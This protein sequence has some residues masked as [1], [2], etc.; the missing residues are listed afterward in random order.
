MSIAD[1][2]ELTHVDLDVQGDAHYPTIPSEFH[3]TASEQQV[4][5]KSGTSFEF[6]T[7]KNNFLV[8]YAI[9][10]HVNLLSPSSSVL[11]IVYSR[12][13]LYFPAFGYA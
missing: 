7:Y 11:Y 9:S 8:A 1:R 5:E 10:E 3:K 12:C 6:A 13:L 4:D 2:L